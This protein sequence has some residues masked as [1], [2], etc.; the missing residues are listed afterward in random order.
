MDFLTNFSIHLRNRMLAMTTIG[1]LSIVAILI[2]FNSQSIKNLYLDSEVLFEKKE[3]LTNTM[4]NGVLFVNST[5]VLKD[6][7]NDV[8]ATNTMKNSVTSLIKGIDKL[9]ILDKKL[10]MKI[11]NKYKAFEDYA[12]KFVD[13]FI[14]KKSLSKS[15]LTK[16]LKV[17]RELKFEIVDIKKSLDKEAKN[18]K[19]AFEDFLNNALFFVLAIIIVIMAIVGG[20]GYLL[21]LSVISSLQKLSNGLGDFFDYMHHKSDSAKRISIKS[22]DEIGMMAESINHNVGLISQ[23]IQNDK[24]LIANVTEVA[25][26]TSLGHF[27]KRIDIDTENKSLVELK[28]IINSML[29]TLEDNIS[30]VT[31]VLGNYSANNYKDRIVKEGTQSSMK[32]M[33]DGINKLGE[34]LTNSSINDMKNGLLLEKDSNILQANVNNLTNSAQEQN[35][36]ID[37]TVNLLKDIIE[38]INN[39]TEKSTQMAQIADGV[40]KSSVE[41]NKLSSQTA[42]AMDEINNSTTEISEAITIINQ[43]AF[44][45][46]ILSLNAAVE[47]AT[48]GEAGKGFAVVAGEVRNL[49]SRSAEASKSIEELVDKAQTKTDEGKNISQKMAD[50]YKVLNENIS[51]TIEIIDEVASASKEQLSKISEINT[52]VDTLATITKK[53]LDI[54]NETNNIANE[55]SLM[56]KR[57]VEETKAKEFESK[58]S[59]KI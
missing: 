38:N 44:Q 53:N 28:D 27:D 22:N 43:I 4:L 20:L 13:N 59:I 8:K 37:S 49:A 35:I 46:N 5:N 2:Y 3:I 6:N 34:S 57:L 19:S 50:G 30:R 40:K 16:R 54:A 14:S 39:N 29:D 25:K 24:K 36:S 47:A 55:T 31:R 48:A 12:P 42:V 41:G 45:T 58:D 17:W 7:P 9:K 51:H 56:A 26:M 32:E 10:Y 11:D 52:S 18:K 33:F 23:N 1:L 15:D 21:S